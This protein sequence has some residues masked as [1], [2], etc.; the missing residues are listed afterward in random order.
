MFNR[1]ALIAATLLFAIGSS[2]CSHRPKTTAPF[3]FRVMTYNIHHGEGMD[4]RIDLRRIAN[5]ILEARADIV[6]LQE[7]DKGVERTGKR[8]LPS[9]LAALTG[10]TCVFSNNHPFQGGEY[11]N[12]VLTR[13]PVKRAGN[14]HF[15][16]LQAKEQRGLQELVLDVD[17]R[18]LAFLNTHLHAGQPET[19]RWSSV[20]EIEQKLK[21]YGQLA[22]LLCGDMNA[23]PD[24][25]VIARLAGILDDT[26]L[27]A[28]EGDGFTVPS[29]GA[30][31]RIDYILKSR[32]PKLRPLKAWVT[33]TEA[34]DH[35]PLTVEFE[36]QRDSSEVK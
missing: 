13:F 14:H 33:Q 1:F 17:G 23:V 28:G 30:R 21:D 35:L 12:A 8:D 15:K 27:L 36:W 26:W 24:S 25:R 5:V 10:M 22:L 32:Y 34:S 4:G 29:T 19:E 11:G 7:V 20:Q 9:E 16:M 31:R 3:T 2:S 6:A 18:R